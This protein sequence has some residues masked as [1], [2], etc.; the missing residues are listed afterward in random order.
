MRKNL[1]L[2][3]HIGCGK[4][5]L[6]RMA[7]GAAAARAGGYVTLRILEGQNLIGFDLAPTPALACP[8]YLEQAAR[9]MDFTGNQKPDLSV[10][11]GLGTRLLREAAEKPFA[12]ADEFGG[13][14][15]LIPE[16]GQAL[17]ELL[18]SPVPCIG[19]IKD[20]D[21]S[22]A[23]SRRMRLG[24]EYKAAYEGLFNWLKRDPN[25]MILRTTGQSDGF[26]ARQ[27]DLWVKEFVRK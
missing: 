17:M 10:F 16:L 21:A 22:R 24:E 27:I 5:T 12:V 20:P 26:A 8:E 25:T 1:L 19:V 23:L 4:S 14:E 18:Q 11:S 15:L 3:G 7:L 6:I 9:F 2:C 13:V